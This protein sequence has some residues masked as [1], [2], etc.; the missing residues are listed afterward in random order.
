M[1]APFGS[2]AGKPPPRQYTQTFSVMGPG[3][4]PQRAP[5]GSF[6]GKPP[7]VP[8]PGSTLRSVMGPGGAPMRP[9]YGSFA[10][11]P[12]MP[13]RGAVVSVM[14]PAGAPMRPP[15]RGSGFH[16]PGRMVDWI[17]RARRRGRR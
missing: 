7:F 13:L 16:G 10:G 5:Y 2:F 14:G 1:R 15:Y 11:K 17:V 9:P 3:G 6:A 12:L 4:A 8:P